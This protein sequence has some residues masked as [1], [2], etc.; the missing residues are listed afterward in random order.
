MLRS[1]ASLATDP[2]LRRR[3][4]RF[5]RYGA[6]SAIALGISEATL[7]VVVGTGLAGATAGALIANAAGVA[8]SYLL[9]RYW[10][11]PEADRHRTGHQVAMYWLVSIVSMLIT[12]FATGFIAHHSPAHG[13]EHVEVIGFA[14]LGVNFLLWIAKF[15]AYQAF[16]FR[17]STAGAPARVAPARDRLLPEDLDDVRDAAA[18]DLHSSPS[19]FT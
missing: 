2:S 9:S 12:S 1:V 4:L 18:C 13:S 8:P 15:G 10:I 7:L 6:T 5:L 16:V 14:F 11:W 19:P 3:V 17:R